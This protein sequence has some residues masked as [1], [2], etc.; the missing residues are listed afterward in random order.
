MTAALLP[1]R[2]IA[3]AYI[4]ACHLEVRALKPGNVHIHADGHGMAM[5]HFDISAEV[6]A[7]HIANPNLKVGAKVRRAIDATFD[8]VGCNTNL[9]IVLLCAPLAAAAGPV[10]GP[11]TYC[12]RLMRVLDTL[13]ETDTSEIFAAIARAN[14]AGLGEA[15][16]GDVHRSPPAGMTLMDAMTAAA[17]RDLIARTYAERFGP[18][19]TLN[20]A[21]MTYCAEGLADKSALARLFLEQLA[22]VPDTHIARKHGRHAAEDVMMRARALIGQLTEEGRRDPSE[23]S[24]FEALLRFDA[25]L[26][27]ERLNPGSHADMMAACVFLRNIEAELSF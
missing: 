27:A 6:S 16:E 11:S 17:D 5:R 25:E 22:A 24:A 12:E 21:L 9:G 3:D 15:P 4:A 2:T 18:L 26:K 23:L 14:P 1:P 19:L 7:P 20:R 13:D 10:N 8:A